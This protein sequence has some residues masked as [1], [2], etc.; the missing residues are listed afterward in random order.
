MKRNFFKSVK[1][2]ISTAS[3]V[4]LNLEIRIALFTLPVQNSLAKCFK[5]VF[6]LIIKLFASPLPH[7]Q[8]MSLNYGDW[9]TIRTFAVA[10]KDAQCILS[11]SL[12]PDD[13][14]SRLATRPNPIK[15]LN[16]CV[17]K[18]N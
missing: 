16:G 1:M 6:W 4:H 2:S 5:K 13:S 17:L 8:L 11:H 7:S 15:T 9:S 18:L 14:G 12:V 3:N 10:I